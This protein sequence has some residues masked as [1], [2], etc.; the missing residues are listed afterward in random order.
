MYSSFQR[1]ERPLRWPLALLHA[2]TSRPDNRP[3]SQAITILIALNLA[4]QLFDGIATYVGWQQFGEANPLLRTG[5]A[6]FGAGPT[7]AV[8]KLAAGLILL[9]LARAPRSLLVVTGLS[10]TLGAYTALSLIPWT[11]LLFA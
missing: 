10:G 1:N 8:T 3:L 6:Y 2:G 7:L 4:L 11:V 9:S 5:F